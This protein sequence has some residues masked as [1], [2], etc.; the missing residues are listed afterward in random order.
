MTLDALDT[1]TKTAL[2]EYLLRLGDDALILGHRLSEWCGHGP[3]L[4]EDIALANIALDCLGHANALLGLAGE[5]E[6]AGQSADDLAFFRDAIEFR[7]VQLVELPRGD[8]AFT[9]A[10]QFLF[11]AYAHLLYEGLRESTF[12]PLAGIAAKAYKEVSYHLRHSSEWMLRLGDGT[13]ESHRRTQQ[14]L[15]DLWMYTGELF[16]ADDVLHALVEAGIAP[17]VP[18]ARSRWKDMVTTVLEAATLQLPPEPPYM[19][20]GGRTGFHTEHLGHLLA[21]MQFL[22]RAYPDATW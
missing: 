20:S 15:N 12:E 13:D 3:Y 11:S 17:D 8:F 4:E 6:G 18:A 14:A 7:N 1:A 10:R 2:F 5:V 16:E 9:I 19:A 21:E 22:P